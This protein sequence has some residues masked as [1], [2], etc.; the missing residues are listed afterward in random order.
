LQR[1]QLT[2][3]S[4]A[5]LEGVVALDDPVFVDFEIGFAHG[6]LEGFKTGVGRVQGVRAGEEADSGVAQLDQ[7]GYGGVDSSRVVEQNGADHGVVE[8]KLGEHDGHVVTR[9][10]IEDRLFTAEGQDGDALDFA[11]QHAAYAAGELAGGVDVGGT[12][13]NFIAVGDG[14]L[15]E[16]GDEFRE[17]GVGDVFDDDAEDAAAPG[18][19]AARVGVGEVVQLLDGLPD[20]LGELLADSGRGVDGA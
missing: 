2:E 4:D 16:A 13:Q 17:E 14:D 6:L 7:M 18:D 3:A 12:D 20:A 19:Q 15:F 10:L 5:A 1:H 11:L 9:K 8:M